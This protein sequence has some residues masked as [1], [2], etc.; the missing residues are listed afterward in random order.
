[1]RTR[2]G[3]RSL[4]AGLRLLERGV[5]HPEDALDPLPRF[6][7]GAGRCPARRGSE[8]LLHQRLRGQLACARE[9]CGG[10]RD[11]PA[12]EHENPFCPIVH[13][14]DQEL[15]SACAASKTVPF[16]AFS[17]WLENPNTSEASAPNLTMCTV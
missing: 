12:D 10:N 14:V 13:S 2:G 9:Q 4:I 1:M 17:A 15:P 5:Q 16:A 7:H 11:Q 3:C 8:R 6:L